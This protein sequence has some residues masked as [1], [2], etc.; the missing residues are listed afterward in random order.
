MRDLAIHASRIF[1]E[2]FPS[3]EALSP[4][5]RFLGSPPVGEG[6]VAAADERLWGFR[7]PTLPPPLPTP[8]TPIPILG[9]CD[10]CLGLLA[11]SL[12]PLVFVTFSFL[13]VTLVLVV[14]TFATVTT[15]DVTPE[16]VLMGHSFPIFGVLL[17]FHL[18]HTTTAVVAV[19][20]MTRSPPCH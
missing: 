2:L 14:T 15:G 6:E 19:R 11:F 9:S 13:Y 12:L 16:V 5:G 20:G 7:V 17:S 1:L 18:Q 10:G 4:C 3:E 8:T